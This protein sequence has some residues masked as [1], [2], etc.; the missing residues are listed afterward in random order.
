MYYNFQ[1]E[2]NIDSLGTPYD[3]KSIMHYGST[4]FARE[5]Y[6]TIETRDK[7]KQYLINHGDRVNDFSEIDIQQINLMY[8]CGKVSLRLRFWLTIFSN[9][10][11]A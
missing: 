5:P 8:K 11:V 10:V 1:I 9:L 4:A 7:S 3:L 2:R 6:Y